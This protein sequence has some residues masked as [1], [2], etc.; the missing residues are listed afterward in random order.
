VGESFFGWQ[1]YDPI[2]TWDEEGNWVGGLAESWTLSPDG[3]TWTFKVRKGV[4]FHNGDPVTSAD[5]M[6]SVQHMQDPT[7]WNPWS[8]YLSYNFDSMSCPDADTFVYKMKEPEPTL[9]M[10]FAATRVLPF[11]Y[12][13]LRGIEYFREHPV[14]SGPWKFVSFTS[15]KECVMEANTEHWRVVPHFQKFI[16][17]V[18]PEEATQVAMLKRGE[19]DVITGITHDTAAKLEAEGWRVERGAVPTSSIL[20]FP[21]TWMTD[22]PMGDIRVR[23]ALAYAIN[24]QEL[25]DT[26]FHGFARPGGRFFMDERVWGWGKDWQPETYDLAKAKSLLADAGYPGKFKNPVITIYV[27]VGSGY[28]PDFMQV[29]QGYW[30]AAGIQTKIE[31]RDAWDWAGMFFVPHFDDPKAP[32][33]GAIFPWVFPNFYASNV[34]HSKNMYTP[35]GVHTTSND[36]KALELY[37]KAIRELDPVKAEQYWTDFQ[38]YCH[39]VMFINF[40]ICLIYDP[41][42]MGPD[43]GEFGWGTWLMGE[44]YADLGHKK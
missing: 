3:K 25:C 13:D 11:E 20:N 5:L 31:M 12:I 18:V 33:V 39:D 40:G 23:Q 17:Y 37:T 34:Y 42:V 6:F 28:T 10:C 35:G 19:V 38:A 1:M 30:T 16:Q 8:P 24:Y 14:G 21:G 27:Q 9:L 22:G 44:A 32:N 4:K 29:L 41:M 2:V 26:F 15:G 36:P 7:S 43:V